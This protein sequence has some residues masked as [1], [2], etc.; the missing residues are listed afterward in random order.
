MSSNAT[1]NW[2]LYTQGET[3]MT[4]TYDEPDASTV[5]FPEWQAESAHDF[6]ASLLLDLAPGDE[7][8][9]TRVQ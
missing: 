6:F 1:Y 7:L 5:S 4:S 9:V 2:T 8:Q 3:F